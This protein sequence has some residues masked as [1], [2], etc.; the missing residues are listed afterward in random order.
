M[1]PRVQPKYEQINSE[2]CKLMGEGGADH[3][4]DP[5]SDSQPRATR[6][7]GE[8]VSH[9]PRGSTEDTCADG[10][11]GRRAT[12]DCSGDRR[13][14]PHQR[15]DGKTVA[16]TLSGRGGR[17]VAR[18]AASGCTPQG[19]GGVS[20]AVGGGCPPSSSQLGV[21]VLAVDAASSG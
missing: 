18:C 17:G 15:G 5:Y 1:D 3:E 16:Q 20:Q 19:D 4:A 12:S 8:V 7:F 14:R 21:A 13:D 10:P 9:Y 2:G 11:A 6:R